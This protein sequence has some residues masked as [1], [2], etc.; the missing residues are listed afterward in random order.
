MIVF[1]GCGDDGM[2]TVLIAV[3]MTVLMTMLTV[4]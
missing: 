1:F 2:M 3:L 4:Y